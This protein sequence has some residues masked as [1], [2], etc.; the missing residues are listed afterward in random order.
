M[1]LREMSVIE[2]ETESFPRPD[3]KMVSTAGAD[4]LT[5]RQILAVE[6]RA[7]IVI[8]TFD[9]EAFSLDRSL[10]E[11]RKL[12]NLFRLSFEPGHI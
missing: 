1:K 4:V 10:F 12:A 2:E 11:G 8:F 6:G 9:E 7:A 5:L 3:S